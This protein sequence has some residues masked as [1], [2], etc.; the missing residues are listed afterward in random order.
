MY[1]NIVGID[2]SKKSFH[3]CENS[4]VNIYVNSSEGYLAFINHLA[5]GS[6]CI[7]ESTSTYGYCLAKA[8]IDSGHHVYIVNPVKIKYFV[9]MGLSKAKTDKIDAK[10][11]TKFGELSID[12]L[13]EYQFGSD[14]IEGSKQIETT[15]IQLKKQ[16]T[17]LLNQLEALLHLPQQSKILI[18]TLKKMIKIFQEQIKLLSNESSNLVKK[19]NLEM[20]KKVSS[21]KGIGESTAILLIAITKSFKN[22]DN[23]K[24]LSSFFGCCPRIIESVPV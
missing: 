6:H 14:E 18:K 7:M 11:I 19:E 4:K 3:A 24:Q 12:T 13:Q 21:I 23:A 22:F 16:Q 9:K 8:L 15:L 17:A 20:V 1:K 10:Q 5:I 2:I